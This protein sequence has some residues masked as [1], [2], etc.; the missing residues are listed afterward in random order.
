PRP[1]PSGPHAPQQNPYGQ[2]YPQ[3]NPYGQQYPQQNPYGQQYPQQNLYGQQFPQQDPYGHQYQQQNPYGQQPQRKNPFAQQPQQHQY[4][5]PMQGVQNDASHM[6]AV[7]NNP[8]QSNDLNHMQPDNQI[9]TAQADQATPERTNSNSKK[10]KVLIAEDNESNYILYESMLSGNY[11]LIHAWNGE[12]AV[13]LFEKEKPD[14]ILMDISMPKMDGYE[15]TT[16]IK[17]I[18]AVVPIIAVTAYAFATDKERM[19]ESG[20]NGYVSKPINLNRLREEM[21]YVLKGK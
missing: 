13:E 2:Q 5:Q 21:K 1:H 11:E 7:E 4:D 17:R 3:Q 20:F 10:L 9:Q 19:M 16:E 18:D 15:A 14:I 6:N 12:E 8:A